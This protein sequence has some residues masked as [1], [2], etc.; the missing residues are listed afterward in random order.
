MTQAQKYGLVLLRLA[1]GWMMLYAG[2]TKLMDPAWSAA[3][4]LSNAATFHG[5]FAWLTTPGILPFINFVN[6]WGLTLLGVSLILGA[7]VRLSSTLGA[8][9]MLLYYF[10]VLNFP[11]IPPHSYIVDDHIVYLFAFLVLAAFR[12]GRVWGMDGKY[13][14][15]R[16]IG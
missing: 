6:E 7:G 13:V 11:N 16:K 15:L 3:G 5:F 14:W 2:V 1:L 10:P 8:L 4:Y 9:L 12:A